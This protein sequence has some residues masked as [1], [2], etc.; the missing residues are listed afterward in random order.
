MLFAVGNRSRRTVQA[1]LP[2]V[3]VTEVMVYE[4]AHLPQRV[5]TPEIAVFTSPSN[6]EAFAEANA[7]APGIKAI[8]AGR[9]TAQALQSKGVEPSAVLTSMS[10]AAVAR[11]IF[12][13]M[14]G[15]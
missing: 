14:L 15:L 9:A 7:F 13:E 12:T 4:T 10:S 6:V 11:A 3:Q 8:A 2:A 5:E 1:A